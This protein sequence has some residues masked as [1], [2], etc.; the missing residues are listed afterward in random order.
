[1]SKNQSSTPMQ[2]DT[3]EHLKTILETVGTAS[4][5][6]GH[7]M[8]VISEPGTGKSSLLYYMAK[9]VFGDYFLPMYC[10]PTTREEEILGYQNPEYLINRRVSEEQGLP[11]WVIDETPFDPRY[12]LIFLN[13]LSRLGDIGADAMIPAIDYGSIRIETPRLRNALAALEG[14]WSPKVFWADSNWLTPTQRNA[15]LRDRFALTVWYSLPVV[16]IARVMSKNEISE[17]KFD[18][19]DVQQINEVRGWLVDWM[20]SPEDTKAYQLILSALTEI[21]SVLD[22]QPF[23]INHRR[24]RQWQKVLFSMAAYE[25]GTPNFTELPTKAFEALSYCYPTIDPSHA[26]AWQSIVMASVDTVATT[27]AHLEGQAIEMW[28]TTFEAIRR[29]RNPQARQQRVTQELGSLLQQFTAELRERFPNDN[30]A[31]DAE[32][33]MYQ[34]YQRILRGEEI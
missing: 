34:I 18:L 21:Q 1:M 9:Q 30:R 22:G 5:L 12:P 15:A 3:S 14:Q 4:L 11:F 25:A 7:N 23:S 31:R 29:E 16:N 20:E 17:W 2:S 8:V 33:R 26:F 13:E 6:S 10:T 28:K 24:V 27:I 19:P 32:G